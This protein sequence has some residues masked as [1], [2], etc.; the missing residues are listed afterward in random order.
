MR[1]ELDTQRKEL[2][3]MMEQFKKTKFEME[4]QLTQQMDLYQMLV[5]HLVVVL[6]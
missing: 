3:S 5:E 4:R 6:Q 1:Q 2:Q